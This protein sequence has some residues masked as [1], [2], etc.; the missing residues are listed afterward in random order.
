MVLKASKLYLFKY[1]IVFLTFLFYVFLISLVFSADD[2]DELAKRS[3]NTK[4]LIL[5]APVKSPQEIIYEQEMQKT[6]AAMRA[7]TRLQR[8][9]RGEIILLYGISSAGKTSICNSLGRTCSEW[10]FESLDKSIDTHL[11]M[12]LQ[13]LFPK[14]CRRVR[15][16]FSNDDIIAVIF[17]GK[18]QFRKSA[19]ALMQK[20]AMAACLHI[21]KQGEL[22]DGSLRVGQ[23]KEEMYERAFLRSQLGHPVVIDA[24]RI[25][26]FVTYKGKCL[27]NC[28]IRYVMLHCPFSIISKRMARRNREAELK[29]DSSNTRYGTHSFF[30]FAKLYRVA[31]KTTETIIERVSRETVQKSFDFNF[32]EDAR[33]FPPEVSALEH[34]IKRASDKRNLLEKL[35]FC[36]SEVNVVH[37]TTRFHYDCFL[38]TNINSADTCA[39]LIG[40]PRVF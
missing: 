22:I 1:K 12:L 35:G 18:G 15:R 36:T 21:K 30:Q 7:S 2:K 6:W 26:D 17:E 33:K 14:E 25:Q 40:N 31:T 23:V 34:E 37:L 27:F 29:G 5:W 19:S 11:V 13:T 8:F 9:G 3:S 39:R 38:D 4:A 20:K 28:P 24:T 16:A 10:S 32:D